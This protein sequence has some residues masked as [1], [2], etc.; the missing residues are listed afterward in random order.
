MPVKVQQLASKKSAMASARAKTESKS[1]QKRKTVQSKPASKKATP[2]KKTTATVAVKSKKTIQ[3]EAKSQA[4]ELQLNKDADAA[5]KT[6]TDGIPDLMKRGES[7]QAIMEDVKKRELWRKGSNPFKSQSAFLEHFATMAHVSIR[8]LQGTMGAIKALPGVSAAK[9]QAIGPRK[10][11]KLGAAARVAASKGEVLPPE[12]IEGAASRTEAEVEEDLIAR[13]L[14][15][16]PEP[17]ED[18]PEPIWPVP[19][20]PERSQFYSVPAEGHCPPVD[21]GSPREATASQITAE[22]VPHATPEPPQKFN[23]T[24]SAAI[25]VAEKLYDLAGDSLTFICAKFLKAQYDGPEQKFQDTTNQ[26]AF[27]EM[28]AAQPKKNGKRK[29]GDK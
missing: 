11:A 25:E 16:R 2:K 7:L 17:Q 18:S 6:L 20:D 14:K 12:V 5:M 23:E 15:Q 10:L 27:D 26:A 4:L 13:G 9:R 1:V 29:K 8:T 24:I 21:L 28:T 22:D 3:A 19:G